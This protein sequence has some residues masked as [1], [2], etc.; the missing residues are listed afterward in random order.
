MYLAKHSNCEIVLNC[1]KKSKG[2]ISAPKI[3]QSTILNVDY[4]EMRGIQIFR[5]FPN[6]NDWILMINR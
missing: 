1:G 6:S 5:F 3:K 4:F 2:G